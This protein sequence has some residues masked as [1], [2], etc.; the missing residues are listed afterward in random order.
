[1]RPNRNLRATRLAYATAGVSM[2]V[3]PGTAA[4]LTATPAARSARGTAGTDSLKV[5]PTPRRVSFGRV[6]RVTGMVPRPGAGQMLA[7]QFAP[8]GSGS[9]RTLT[10][11]TVRANGSFRL[12]APLRRSGSLRVLDATVN[13]AGQS[14]GLLEPVAAA[15]GPSPSRYVGV[16]AELRV[17]QASQGVLSGQ[18][19]D[20]RGHLLPRVFGRQV[21]LQ[22][23][24]GG[25]WRTL[26][27]ARTGARGG[28][29]LRYVTGAL[30]Q[31]PLRVRFAGDRANGRAS[32]RAGQITVYRQ[33]VASWYDDAG[34]TACGFHAYFAV[35]HKYLPCG[36]QVSFRYGG[37]A[38][39]ATVDD[40]GPFIA[41]R[42]WDLNQN[43]ASALGFGGVGTVWSSR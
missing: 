34:A 5:D 29:D 11:T 37:Q 3:I 43:T 10:T 31:T 18:T 20:V 13:A 22:G 17:R 32:V 39:T 9:W 40:R 19:V 2:L 1:V 26:A 27:T 16:A 42:E 36:T 6:V 38:V 14:V 23:R 30:G 25:T 15:I 35:A 8:A 4:A 24:S 21:R 7:L 33:S 28:F 12:D 41:G